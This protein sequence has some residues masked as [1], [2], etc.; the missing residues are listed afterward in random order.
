VTAD[1]IWQLLEIA[2]TADATAIRRAYSRRLKALDVDREPDAFMAL[3]EARDLAMAQAAEM[4]N[5]AAAAS[6][7]AGS[8]AA[9]GKGA[10]GDRTPYSAPALI[11]RPEDAIAGAITVPAPSG[12][13]IA[14]YS[15]APDARAA[16]REAQQPS[17][18][19]IAVAPTDIPVVQGYETVQAVGIHRSSA[20][21]G[22][23]ERY[24][25][26]VALLF[27][28]EGR[29][30]P[31]SAE[32]QAALA[33]HF[34]ALLA[35]PR[36]AEVAFYADAERWFSETL[37]RSAPWSD[38]IL[39]RAATFFGWLDRTGEINLTPAVTFVTDRVRMLDF[40]LAVQTKG[41][42][43]YGAWRELRRPADEHA[44]RG[45]VRRSKVHELLALVR[46]DYPGLEECFDW[47]RV[48]MWEG[49]KSSSWSGPGIFLMAFLALQLLNA[50]S[51]CGNEQPYTPPSSLS[52]PK[53][54]TVDKDLTARMDADL[55]F[56]LD[57]IFDGQLTLQEIRER[58][59]AL[60]Q[61]LTS[62]WFV[63]HDANADRDQ[64]VNI[65]ERALRERA[66][67]GRGRLQGQMLLDQRRLDLD[68]ALALKARD[69]KLCDEFFRG[70]PAPA[71][72]ISDEL[73]A[74]QR[75]L[76]IRVLMEVDGS[77]RAPNEAPRSFTLSA[78]MVRTISQKA[79]IDPEM[80]GPALGDGGTASQRCRVRIALLEAA[81]ALPAAER[82]KLLSEI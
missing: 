7:D 64:L 31:H 25:A 24:H 78:E 5:D 6:R 66:A 14:D 73:R 18:G 15:A 17:A 32:E 51:K 42:P 28:P 4:A 80:L 39:K 67:R 9:E 38:T 48:S 13:E 35:D 71:K 53:G 79:G 16:I 60:H 70:A 45:W 8:V 3:R 43:L 54:P 63:A 29:Q 41:H 55:G 12:V 56:A 76:T 75:N 22:L 47:Y 36:M 49:E 1:S 46:R 74:R 11:D 68:L 61:T 19:P 52:E 50:L 69:V 44:T 65:V 20:P 2:P 58:N 81:L 77:P 33:E 34:E 37:A 40:L 30:E 57:R 27:P 10:A 72:F 62:N 23:E 21:E 26:F 59:L 82:L